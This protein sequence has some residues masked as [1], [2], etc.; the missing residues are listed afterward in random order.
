MSNPHSSKLALANSNATHLV[1]GRL[2]RMD[3]KLPSAPTQYVHDQFRALVLSE[4]FPCVAARSSMNTA[5]YRIGL[6]EKM[7]SP[8]AAAGLARDLTQFV[9]DGAPTQNF[10][11]FVA[12]FMYPR[13]TSEV[14]F[15]RLLFRQLQMLH[16]LDREFFSWNETVSN[17]PSAPDFAFSFAGQA[18]F[19]AGLHAGSRMWGRV[20]AYPTLVFNH[21]LQF[22]RLRIVGKFPL[23]KQAI[24]ERQVK[25]QG[26]AN[27]GLTDHGDGSEARDYA[28]RLHETLPGEPWR[29][30]FHPHVL[31][32]PKN[33]AGM[34]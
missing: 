7:G 26:Y 14:Q 18:F 32:K 2:V 33:D 19:V 28:G 1:E 23:L 16:D 4:G 3:G 12:T 6:Y 8:G 27:P 22:R 5:L 34:D 10:T 20:F 15:E 21:H 13:P 17:D 30:P 9:L 24:H 11:S 25:L 29:C 31:A